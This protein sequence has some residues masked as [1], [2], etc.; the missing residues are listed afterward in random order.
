MHNSTTEVSS[1]T[2]LTTS[3]LLSETIENLIGSHVKTGDLILQFQRRS[4][5]GVLLILALLAMVPG[6]SVFAGAAMIVP[7]F[8]LMIGLPAPVFPASIRSRP[9]SVAAL[10]RWTPKVIEWLAKVEKLIKPR[11]PQ[12]TTQIARRMLGLVVIVLAL[13]VTIPFP[14]SNFPPSFAV[15]CLALG[16]LER[17]GLMITLGLAIS[18]IACAVGFIVFYVVLGWISQI[19]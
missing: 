14:F 1:Q 16:I 8:Q 3:E 7:A 19:F 4:F 18:V 2:Y 17:D 11:W 5:G 9:I 6:I 13:I 15:I 10:R 12:L